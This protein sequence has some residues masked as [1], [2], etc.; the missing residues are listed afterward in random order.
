[1]PHHRL[2]SSGRRRGLRLIMSLNS[3]PQGRSIESDLEALAYA[4]TTRTMLWRRDVVFLS[5]SQGSLG[6]ALGW[7]RPVTL[8]INLTGC[9]I[10]RPSFSG[11]TMR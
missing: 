2:V 1:M 4:T 3:K 10:V 9:R 7:Q 6:A 11:T 5:A 8:R